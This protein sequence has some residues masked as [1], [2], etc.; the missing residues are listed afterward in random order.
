MSTKSPVPTLTAPPEGARPRARDAAALLDP[1]GWRAASRGQS[2]W[3]HRLRMV[4]GMLPALGIH[5][6]SVDI[7]LTVSDVCS[8]KVAGPEPVARVLKALPSQ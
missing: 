4:P 6:L 8:A 2:A 3:A 7:P 5:S 1:P